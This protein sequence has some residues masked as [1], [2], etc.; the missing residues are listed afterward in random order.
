MGF[1]WNANNCFFTVHY[2]NAPGPS[3]VF[4]SSSQ[5]CFFSL[6][7]PPGKFLVSSTHTEGRVLLLRSICWMCFFS[8]H[9]FQTR[10]DFLGQVDVPLSHLPVSS[11]HV[12]NWTDCFEYSAVSYLHFSLCPISLCED[13]ARGVQCVRVCVFLGHFVRKCKL[14][15]TVDHSLWERK[16]SVSTE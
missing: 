1:P 14:V 12:C 6:S 2:I 16:D 8:P 10:D 5:N 11:L 9:L 13:Q 3:G 7:Y 15:V 4:G